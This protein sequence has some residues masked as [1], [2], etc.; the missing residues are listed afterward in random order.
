MDTVGDEVRKSWRLAWRQELWLP[1]G[2]PIVAVAYALWVGLTGAAV[3]Y[4]AGAVAGSLTFDPWTG[5]TDLV[6]AMLALLWVVGPAAIAAVLV[7]D[8]VTNVRG[9]LATGYRLR[10]PLLLFLP[11]VA[12][13]GVGVAGLATVGATVPVLAVLVVGAGWLPVRTVA[14]AARV[15][16]L[17]LPVVAHAVTFLTAAA[18]AVA[19]LVLA[20]GAIGRGA[21]VD[22][23]T[24]GLAARTGVDGVASLASGTVDVVGAPL[25]AALA[26]VVAVPVGLS[27]A[28]VGVQLVASAVARVVKPTVR[29]PELRT[30]QRYPAFARPTS[31]ATPTSGGGGSQPG[32]GSGPSHG[33]GAHSAA[34]GDGTARG[35][36]D[37]D[38]GSPGTDGDDTR[39]TDSDDTG[40]AGVDEADE[41][42]DVVTDVS[43]TRV[44]TPSE[45][46]SSIDPDAVANAEAVEGGDD[47][48]EADSRCPDCGRTV[49]DAPRDGTCPHCGAEF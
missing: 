21:L 15:F 19:T 39:D 7:R 20:A 27:T 41:P 35:D 1:V 30:G 43:Q 17:S 3:T 44:F 2:A 49:P 46:A 11:P 22:A 31:G 26:A 47:A 12:V 13:L 8:R 34:N 42:P 40:P 24:T 9:N 16:S 25:P 33:R 45:D 10:H 23:V 14:Y 38:D 36:G 18:V 32:G 6:V 5:L 48:A 37:D 29:R 28:Y 4:L